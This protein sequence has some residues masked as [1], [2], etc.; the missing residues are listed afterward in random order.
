M[1]RTALTTVGGGETTEPPLDLT[2]TMVTRVV[3]ATVGGAA[4]T[5]AMLGPGNDS[6]F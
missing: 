4:V 5:T 2:V 3:K 1:T 6:T